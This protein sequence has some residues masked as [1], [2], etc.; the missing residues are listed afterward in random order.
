M[1]SARGNRWIVADRWFSI[2]FIVA[3]LAYTL[4]YMWVGLVRTWYFSSDEY[5]VVA[6]VIRFAQHQYAQRFFDMPGTP[7]IFLAALAW[8]F[9]Y[10]PYAILDDR[11]AQIGLQTFTF[12]HLPGLFF[13]V[14]SVTVFMFCAS[15]V[16]LFW[17][18]SKLTSTAAGRLAA[19]LLAM[20]PIYAKYS[21]F[22]R[23]ESTAMCFVLGALL[24]VIYAPEARR[25]S[26]SPHLDLVLLAGVLAGVAA[27][28]RLHSMTA[29]LPVLV[30]LLVV[31][32]VSP[33][34]EDYPKWVKA[35][36]IPVAGAVGLAAAALVFSH[37]AFARW[38]NTYV[39][40]LKTVALAGCAL[41]GAI[42]CYSIRPAR[43]LLIRI[44][45][46]DVIKVLIGFAVGLAVSVPTIVGGREFFFQSVQMYSS[47]Y[48]DWA[49]ARLPLWD[50][51]TQYLRGYYA[52]L[53]PDGVVVGLLI[54]GAIAVVISRNRRLLAILVG[55]ALFFVSKPL[56]LR[57]DEHHIILWLPY[58]AIVC[59][60]PAHLLARALDRWPAIS[61]S[62]N[63]ALLVAVGVWTTHGPVV[64]ALNA[65]HTE[66]RMANIAT[67]TKWMKET[68]EPNATI[69][70]A[71][72]CFN[73]DVF[74][75]QLRLYEVPMPLSMLDGR[76]YI[77]WWGHASALKKKSGYVCATPF[78]VDL[79]KTTLDK[80]APGEGTDPFTDPGMHLVK[81]FGSA[82]SEVDV[83]RFDNRAIDARQ[84]ELRSVGDKRFN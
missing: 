53:A 68:A 77:I 57:S 3:L 22:V 14:R 72:R 13:T 82:D 29:S 26:W 56:N 12:A 84:A 60:Y 28:A 50:N 45:S 65:V 75:S 10:A 44:I 76:D 31:S 67:A 51:V 27:G 6:E 5:V 25:R 36:V 35:A 83:F 17:L 80:T 8:F 43:S 32:P 71:Y 18:T 40:F 7:F 23:V 38:P 42:A 34:A 46:P 61:T 2:V 15:V 33:A 11:I 64:M 63:A 73:P 55:A 78:D 21:S 54:A 49:R 66:M 81:A 70:I 39:L 74:L 37:P 69:A 59:A 30:L 4:R 58:Y 79:L 9:I 1:T 19:L 48:I 62:V 47:T 24:C 20:S 16:L 41:A 52:V